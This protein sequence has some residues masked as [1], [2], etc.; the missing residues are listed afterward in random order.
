VD[1]PK[2]YP[3]N[4]LSQAEVEQ[5]FM[6]MATWAVSSRQAE[7]IVTLVRKVEQVADI[8]ELADMLRVES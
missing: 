5:K 4:P 8:G 1:Y 3:E 6:N 2:G 7:K